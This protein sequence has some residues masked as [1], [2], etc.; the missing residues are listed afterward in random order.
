MSDK[1][2][3][4]RIDVKP[5]TG[6]NGAWEKT[7]ISFGPQDFEKLDARK[8]DKGWVNLILQT[9]QSTGKKYLEVDQF[10]PT[11]ASGL[12]NTPAPNMDLP[13][14]PDDDLPF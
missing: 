8:N 1:I 9:S 4:G 3:I 5:M 11:R 14:V 6:A 12:E 10:V 13:P 7:T 2:F